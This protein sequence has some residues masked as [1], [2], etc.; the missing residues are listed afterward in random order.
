MQ[1][2]IIA[3]DVNE[4]EKF[5]LIKALNDWRS[6]SITEDKLDYKHNEIDFEDITDLIKKVKLLNF[7]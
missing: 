2:K 3:L 7:K 1:L 4:Q 5:I 6:K